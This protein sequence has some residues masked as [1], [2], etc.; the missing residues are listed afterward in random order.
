MP[1]RLFVYGTLKR[2]WLAQSS[3]WPAAAHAQLQPIARS[4]LALPWL[5]QA[6]A[7]GMLYRVSH[8]P[9][10]VP[11]D[12]GTV[13]GELYQ[14]PDSSEAV[15]ALLNLLDAYEECS[16]QDPHPQ[17]YRRAEILVTA[18]DGQRQLAWTYCYNRDSADFEPI[19]DGLFSVGNPQS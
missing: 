17:E 8:Y 4:L 3:G 6:Q 10:F 18:A 19:I 9:A 16:A 12:S 5:G 2:D 7:T 15:A 11:A 1:E 13:F 14:L